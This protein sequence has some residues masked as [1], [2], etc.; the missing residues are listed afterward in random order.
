MQ[1]FRAYHLYSRRQVL[2]FDKEVAKIA[3]ISVFDI[4][5][6]I[7]IIVANIP[8]KFHD[9]ICFWQEIIGINSF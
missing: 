5:K 6:A 8:N 9:K 4:Q 2:K 3:K 7:K 1:H